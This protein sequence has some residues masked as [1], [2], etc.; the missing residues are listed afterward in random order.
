MKNRT[1]LLVI[2]GLLSGLLLICSTGCQSGNFRAAKLP[3]EFRIARTAS[4]PEDLNLSQ[5]ASP[6]MPTDMLAPGDLLE[7]TIDS[8]RDDETAEPILARVAEN[9]MID[10]PIVGP[11]PVAGMETVAASQQIVNAAIQRGMYL[12]PLVTIETKERAVNRITILGAVNEPG[13]HEL[14][15]ANCNLINALAAAGGLSESA[16]TQVEI[17]RQSGFQLSSHDT[18]NQSPSSQS[19]ES[20]EV[21]LASYHNGGR[22]QR[23]APHGIWSPQTLRLD[24]TQQ[25]FIAPKAQSLSDRDVI[26][27][28]PRVEEKVHVA[29]LVKHPGQFSLPHDQDIRLLDAIAMAG[30]LTSPVAD[31]VFIIRKVEEKKQPILIQASISE[32]K[33]NGLENLRLTAGD[34]ITVEQTVST[35]IVD[36]LTKFFRLSY[37][38]ASSTTF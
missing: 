12:H 10:L 11:V 5:I 25:N 28:L 19:N 33:K 23:N 26:R 36:T 34:T 24:L 16:S 32:S 1:H 37:G 2:P 17:I 7:V 8:G 6:G 20:D 27:I 4:T 31:K 3:Q 30:G 38:V 21:Q 35:A 13:V 22:N 29:G 15:K 14:P 9:G 18:T